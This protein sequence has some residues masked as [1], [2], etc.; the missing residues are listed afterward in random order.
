[1]K[2]TGPY[3]FHYVS[4]RCGDGGRREREEVEAVGGFQKG[5]SGVD[6]GLHFD[7]K[8]SY[9]M[10]IQKTLKR[11]HSYVAFSCHCHLHFL[12]LVWSW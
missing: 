4:Y 5:Y 3:W 2:L 8:A 9:G 12:G 11:D 1:M 7:G 6:D 10:N